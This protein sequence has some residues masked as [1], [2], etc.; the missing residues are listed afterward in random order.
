MIRPLQ[1]EQLVHMLKISTHLPPLG[2]TDLMAGILYALELIAP[3]P[4]IWLPNDSAGV[5]FTFLN[6]NDLD[7]EKYHNL[8]VTPK[9]LGLRMNVG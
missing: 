7:H 1:R 5:S 8:L 9:D 6:Q 4:I 3:P 2:Y